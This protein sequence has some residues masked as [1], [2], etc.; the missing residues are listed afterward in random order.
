[1]HSSVF[2]FYEAHNVGYVHSVCNRRLQSKPAHELGR[3][4][5]N[6]A[7]FQ[8]QS[9]WVSM[10]GLTSCYQHWLGIEHTQLRGLRQLKVEERELISC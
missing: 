1:M 8:E 4:S 7:L 10:P 2:Q 3:W 9:S 6:P 5:T